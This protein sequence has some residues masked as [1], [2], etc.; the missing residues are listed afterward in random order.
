ME[1]WFYPITP[2]LQYSLA[3]TW[4][5]E[6]LVEYVKCAPLAQTWFSPLSI[7]QLLSRQGGPFLKEGSKE[8]AQSP[9]PKKGANE[10]HV[11]G[12]DSLLV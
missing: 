8:T 9:P 2:L 10:S 5:T 3:Q 12:V 7:V 6:H 4:L 11:L 1:Y